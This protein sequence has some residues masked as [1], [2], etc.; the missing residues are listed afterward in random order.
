VTA[1]TRRAGAAPL[2]YAVA[3]V[4]AVNL[5]SQLAGLST[6]ARVS[7][8]LFMPLLGAWAW[9][10]AP[11]PLPRPLA[12]LLVGIGFAWGGD[13][14][15]SLGGDVTFAVGIGSF[16]VM[17]VLYV[18]AFRA[19]PGPGLVRA[20]PVAWIPYVLVWAGMNWLIRDGVGVLAVPVL[21]YSAALVVMAVQAL[22]L[23]LRVPRRLGWTI[24]WGGALFVV[25]DG[26]I[27]LR[28]F[29]DLLPDGRLTSF[30]TMITYI[31][32]QVMI[33]TGFVRAVTAVSRPSPSAATS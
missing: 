18:L 3:V 25:S 5:L 19:V 13:V 14:L 27:A 20:W 21:V 17:Q 33:V 28:A 1:T 16:L 11:R 30:A 10:A 26:L 32:A 8:W 15:L 4:A 29:A 22:D 24:A 9:V 31:A 2:L 12:L 7:I 6:G 23:V